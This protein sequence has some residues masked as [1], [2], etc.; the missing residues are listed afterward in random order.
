MVIS[1]LRRQ[2][3]LSQ[4]RQTDCDAGL[5]DQG[6]PHILPDFPAGAHSQTAEISAQIFPRNTDQEISDSYDS[7]CPQGVHIQVHAGNNEKYG[8]DRRREV[9]DLA[10]QLLIP[11]QI[12]ISRAEHHTG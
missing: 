11:G 1:R 4:K 7:D 2:E 9:I 12:D 10:E 3:P 5:R 6:K 8:H